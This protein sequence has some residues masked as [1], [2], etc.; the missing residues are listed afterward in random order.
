MWGDR[1]SSA[2]GT[3]TPPEAAASPTL[4]LTKQY[5][6]N[7]NEDFVVGGFLH[8]SGKIRNTLVA[9]VPNEVDFNG[10]VS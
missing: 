5:S 3:P 6:H 4:P 1:S 9:E 8:Q 2:T 7:D 10:F